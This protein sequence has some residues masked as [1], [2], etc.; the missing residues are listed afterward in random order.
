MDKPL[1]VRPAADDDL[2]VETPE[3][4]VS[5]LSDG[6]GKLFSVGPA[7]DDDLQNDLLIVMVVEG[8]AVSDLPPILFMK[9][10]L[11]CGRSRPYIIQK[12]YFMKSPSI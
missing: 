3:I 12:F 9:L 8:S 5:I 4:G 10:K 7:T 6:V 1:S 2:Y 11:Y